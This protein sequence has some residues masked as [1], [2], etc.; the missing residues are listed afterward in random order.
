MPTLWKSISASARNLGDSAAKQATKAKLKADMALIDRSMD[1]R[2]RSFGVA[3]YDYL[4]PLSQSADFYAATDK[5]TEL[6]RPLL[7]NAQ[8]EI[9]ALGAKRVK[10][11]EA[12]AQAESNRAAAFPTK[13]ETFS[14]SLKNFG[15]ASYLHGGETKI[16]TELSVTD[17]LIKGHK[18][19]DNDRK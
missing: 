7:I 2:K 11:K 8:K 6:I 13:A 18:Q 12:L 4:S 9:Q 14:Q 3:M 5:L 15:K 16:K 17:R 19:L 1:N 10:Q